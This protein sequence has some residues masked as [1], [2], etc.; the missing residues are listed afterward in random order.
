M[1]HIKSY[2]INETASW[3]AENAHPSIERKLIAL[4][5]DVARNLVG[6][7][8]AEEVRQW[9]VDRFNQEG[10]DAFID[11]LMHEAGESHEQ[12]QNGERPRGS[13]NN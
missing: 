9:V 1:K 11:Y 3:D 2:K 13:N 5:T 4:F 7:T 12:V 8:D 10:T 6:L